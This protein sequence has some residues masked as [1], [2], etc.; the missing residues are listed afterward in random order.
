MICT[1]KVIEI[2]QEEEKLAKT[3]LMGLIWNLVNYSQ[4]PNNHAYCFLWKKTVL[5]KR[6]RKTKREREREREDDKK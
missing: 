1:S 6:K 2:F 3:F 4:F 5:G